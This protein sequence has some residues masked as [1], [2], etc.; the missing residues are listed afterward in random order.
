[1]SEHFTSGFLQ[2]NLE[3]FASSA[4]PEM[5]YSKIL[6]PYLYAPV[7]VAYVAYTSGLVK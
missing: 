6:F 2:N 5:V 1:M 3:S 7:Y 4:D